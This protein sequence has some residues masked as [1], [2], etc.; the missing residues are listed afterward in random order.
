MSRLHLHRTV[1]DV[2]EVA[3]GLVVLDCRDE[4]V[5]SR[6]SNVLKFSDKVWAS[7]CCR[8][9]CVLVL[10]LKPNMLILSSWISI[11]SEPLFLSPL[12]FVAI[13]LGRKQ[14]GELVN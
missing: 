9:V 6:M 7:G 4:G 12:V 2:S 13:A 11:Y 14:I 5:N 8:S 3:I 1:S 10:C